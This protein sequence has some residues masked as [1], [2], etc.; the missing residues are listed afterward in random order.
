LPTGSP[1]LSMSPRSFFP[2]AGGTLGRGKEDQGRDPRSNEWSVQLYNLV[3]VIPIPQCLWGRTPELRLFSRRDQKQM[4]NKREDTQA[5]T[6]QT[7]AA[8]SLPPGS[9]LP[10]SMTQGLTL[11]RP[12]SHTSLSS[13]SHPGTP[14]RAPG[15][16]Q[17]SLG[18]RWAMCNEGTWRGNEMSFALGRSHRIYGGPHM[19]ASPQPTHKAAW[20]PRRCLSVPSH[21]PGSRLSGKK[22][23]LGD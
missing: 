3:D 21:L 2:S 13:I 19:L 11:S 8:S 10:A 14:V 15:C 23:E 1:L 9:L 5:H 12:N 7:A 18:C 22:M 20:I 17:N 4:V 16:L 6:S